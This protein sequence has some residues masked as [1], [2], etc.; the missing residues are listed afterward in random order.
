MEGKDNGV[1]ELTVFSGTINHSK[2]KIQQ[3]TNVQCIVK[4]ELNLDGSEIFVLNAIYIMQQTIYLSQ[5]NR[6]SKS[7]YPAKN[8]RFLWQQKL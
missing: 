8:I 6:Q 3:N 2:W 7:L 1:I 4:T 5:E